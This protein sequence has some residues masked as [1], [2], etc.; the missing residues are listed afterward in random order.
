MRQPRSRSTRPKAISPRSC[1]SPGGQASS[2]ERPATRPPVAAEREHAAAQERRREVLLG[3]RDLAALPALPISCSTGS[4]T[5]LATASTVKRAS[6]S[7]RIALASASSKRLERHG[8]PLG[9]VR[10]LAGRSAGAAARAS[11]AASRA[12]SA[13]ET[14]ESISAF[15]ALHPLLVARCRRGGSRRGCAAGGAGRS[16]APRRAACRRRRRCAG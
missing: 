7:S 9:M 2:G 12:A 8:Q 14:P 6:A 3:H 1:R 10:R 13:A 4:S 15:I 11:V 16:A 5:R